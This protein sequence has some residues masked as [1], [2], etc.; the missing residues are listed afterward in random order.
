M[1]KKKRGGHQ[2]MAT[3]PSFE[4]CHRPLYPQRN[5]FV[6]LSELNVSAT[7]IANDVPIGTKNKGVVFRG[8][9]MAIFPSA[10]VRANF[11]QLA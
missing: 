1:I 6:V 5:F 8:K 3:R 11:T 9:W 2:K 7:G 4:A 10:L